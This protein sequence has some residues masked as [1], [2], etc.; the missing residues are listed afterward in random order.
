[1][2]PDM[3]RKFPQGESEVGTND[4]AEMLRAADRRKLERLA[5]RLAADRVAMLKAMRD[6]QA[7]GASLRE[8][9]QAAGMSHTGVAKWLRERDT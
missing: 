3:A 9:A 5:R 6:A 8:I 1:M 7:R 2:L 4:D